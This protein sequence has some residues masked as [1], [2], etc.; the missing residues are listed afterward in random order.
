MA[1]N[2]IIFWTNC[3][4]FQANNELELLIDHACIFAIN[5]IY[6]AKGKYSIDEKK[7][8]SVFASFVIAIFSDKVNKYIM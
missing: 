1:R 6:Y 5:N 3:T 7:S 4:K 8:T 2:G